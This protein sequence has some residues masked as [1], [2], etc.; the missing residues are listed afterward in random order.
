[1]STAKA[2]WTNGDSNWAFFFGAETVAEA[3]AIPEEIRGKIPGDYGRD[4]GVGWYFLGGYGI[5]HTTASQARIVM[6]DSAA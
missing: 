5:M 4:K 2:L 1:M 3:I 6:W